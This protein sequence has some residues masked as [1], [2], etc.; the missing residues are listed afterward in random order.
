LKNTRSILVGF[1]LL[2]LSIAAWGQN[3]DRP[4]GSGIPG[5]LDPRT[6]TFRPVPLVTGNGS[7]GAPGVAP[8]YG[9]IV[10]N[11]NATLEN[12]YPT[13]ENYSCGLTASAFDASSGLSFIDSNQV[14]ATKTGNT[15]SCTVTLTYFWALASPGSDTMMVE[16][17]VNAANA[18]GGVP[19]RLANHGVA[20]FIVPVSGTT[21]TYS[22]YI[23][24]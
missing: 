18:A 21:T 9:K 4:A 15:L 2:G 10:L 24:L 13:G 16:Y 1:C 17:S 20:N 11:L 19:V 23:L 14:A 22:F 5:Y 12:T 7:V 3:V 8:T 6:G